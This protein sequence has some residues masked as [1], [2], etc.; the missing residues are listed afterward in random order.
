MK[1]K[2]TTNTKIVYFLTKKVYYALDLYGYYIQNNNLYRI[3]CLP[4]DHYLY[5]KLSKKESYKTLEELM[6]L[7]E[8]KYGYDNR[9][10]TKKIS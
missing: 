7:L 8:V 10:N 3:Y 5:N 1:K 6:L 2:G 4:I 9:S